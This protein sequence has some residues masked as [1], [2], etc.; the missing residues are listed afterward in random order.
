MAATALSIGG[1]KTN[2]LRSLDNKTLEELAIWSP[3]AIM[4]FP[5]KKSCSRV[6]ISSYVFCPLVLVEPFIRSD[7]SFLL[8]VMGPSSQEALRNIETLKFPTKFLP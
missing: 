7:A 8:S 3:L 4:T 5:C 6:D 2:S 1:R